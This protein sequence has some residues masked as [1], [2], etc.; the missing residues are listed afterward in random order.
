[1]TEKQRLH[2]YYLA[3]RQEFIDRAKKWAKEHPERTKELNKIKSRNYEKRHRVKRLL[4]SKRYYYANKQKS[5]EATKLYYQKY[6]EKFAGY[7][8]KQRYGL[9]QERFEQM[10]VEQENRC[11]VCNDV[12]EVPFVDHDH[13]TQ[14]VRQLLCKKCNSFIGLA[15]ES[16]II[17]LSA[18]QYLR[19]HGSS[20]GTTSR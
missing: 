14:Q 12:L 5:Y 16:E 4:K 13:K 3:H 9:T 7:A 8:R 15:R 6:P 10:L 1:M 2:R 19:K 11:A 20:N 18:I 17:L